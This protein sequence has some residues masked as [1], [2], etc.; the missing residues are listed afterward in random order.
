MGADIPEITKDTDR[1][2]R[3]GHPRD[4]G[5]PPERGR[6]RPPDRPMTARGFHG[7]GHPPPP[8]PHRGPRPPHMDDYRGLPNDPHGYGRG[9]PM[10]PGGGPSG[11]RHR[12]F[13]A[14]FD[15]DPP[16]MSPNPDACE[17]ELPFREGQLIKVITEHASLC[18]CSVIYLQTLK[19]KH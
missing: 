5:G 16:T 14:L 4:Y 12:V 3:F 19:F 1:H 13:V 10:R 15:Y 7:P 2:G 6:G 17:E 18:R 11:V 8:G 9:R